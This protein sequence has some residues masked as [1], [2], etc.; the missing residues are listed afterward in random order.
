MSKKLRGAEAVRQAVEPLEGRWLLAAEFLV[1]TTANAG[2]G[3]L[4]QAIIDANDTAGADVIKFQIEGAER[5]IRPTSAL[6]TVTDPVTIDGTSQPGFAGTPVIILD[7]EVAGDL[8]NGLT[9][10]GGGST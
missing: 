5:T 2:A 10:T 6:P 9:I 1:T 4:R 8:V 3:S 7:G